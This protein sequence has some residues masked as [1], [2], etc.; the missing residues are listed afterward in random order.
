M[1]TKREMKSSY[2]EQQS[3]HPCLA[4]DSMSLIWRL[5]FAAA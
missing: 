1:T 5:V 3:G 4:L 2:T